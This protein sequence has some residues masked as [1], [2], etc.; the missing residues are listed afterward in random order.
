[1]K[2]KK[3]RKNLSLLDYYV[4]F[5]VFWTTFPDIPTFL[6]FI[7]I[8][9]KAISLNHLTRRRKNVERKVKFS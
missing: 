5:P 4:V 3:K 2:K 9:F 7:I 8:F 1:M 6:I